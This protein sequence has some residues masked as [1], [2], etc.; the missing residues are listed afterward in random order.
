MSLATRGGQ[1]RA[2]TGAR[3]D[4]MAHWF[5]DNT[6]SIGRTPLVAST[7]GGRREGAPS[8]EDRGAKPGVLVKCRIGAAMVWDAERR[9]VLGPGKE[10]IEPTSGKHGYRARVRRRG[11]R[12]SA[13]ADDAGDDEH[14]APQLLS[15]Y[16]AKLVLTPGPKG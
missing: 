5:E 8:R 15:A 13:H 9:G 3:E 6:L 10:L 14:G 1:R 7:A 16:G 11:A 12:L 2:V 4:P